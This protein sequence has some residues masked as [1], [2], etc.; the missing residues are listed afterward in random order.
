MPDAFEYV[1]S[2]QTDD[3]QLIDI[4]EHTKTGERIEKE[5]PSDW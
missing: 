5:V 3:G 2:Y 1:D 4:Y